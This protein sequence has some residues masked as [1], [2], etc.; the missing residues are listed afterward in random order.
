MSGTNAPTR[1]VRVKASTIT[2]RVD[3]VE[4]RLGAE[5]LARFR[6]AASPALAPYL[7]SKVPSG[8]A[9]FDAFVE[10][11]VLVDRLFG[12]GD[13][14]LAW[15]MGRFAATHNMGMWKAFVY[16]HVQPSLIMSIAAGLWGQHYDGGR[17]ATR[18]LGSSGVAV[19]IIDFPTPHRAHC[20][21]VGGWILGTAEAGPRR[22]ATVRESACRISGDRLCEL[23][24]TWEQ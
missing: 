7:T 15:D 2:A 22:S 12:D 21:S 8:W 19:S 9:A 10:A 11:N 24:V 4:Q 1:S 17:L 6:E 5:A 14:R 20:L 13:L 3:Y 16:R 23:L 18:P